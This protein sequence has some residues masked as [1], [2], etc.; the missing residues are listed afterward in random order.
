MAGHSK[1]ANIRFRKAAQDARRGKAFTKL[2]KEITVAA[3]LG[4]DDPDSNPGLRSAI[5]KALAANMTRDTINRAVKRGCGALAGD[6]ISEIRYEG[7][8]PAGVAILVECAT[9]NKNRTASDVRHAF[10]KHGGNLGTDGSVAW[11]FRKIGSLVFANGEDEEEIM[12]VALE[13]GAEDVESEDG[14]IEV[15]APPGKFHQVR[16]AMQA[17]G[18]RAEMAEI[19]QRPLT[20]APVPEEDTD[21]VMKLIDALEDLDDVQDVFTNASFTTREV[22]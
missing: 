3:R 21:K 6:D 12:G 1:W 16:E 8:G 2:I 19:I 10:T 4:G 11:L 15:V 7:Y 9:D 18:L 17:A 22:K 13:A 14:I 20:E 5:D